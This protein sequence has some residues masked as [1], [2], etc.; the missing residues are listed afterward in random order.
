MLYHSRLRDCFVLQV[1][2]L[3]KIGGLLLRVTSQGKSIKPEM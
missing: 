3:H 1:F 2:A